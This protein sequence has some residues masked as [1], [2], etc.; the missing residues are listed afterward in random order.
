MV[1][2]HVAADIL[3]PI[4]TLLHAILPILRRLTGTPTRPNARTIS[5]PGSLADP[6]SAACTGT[7]RSARPVAGPGALRDGRPPSG[8]GQLPGGPLLGQIQEPL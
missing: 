5:R 4:P 3:G 8:G 7:L 2:P 1:V 6:R